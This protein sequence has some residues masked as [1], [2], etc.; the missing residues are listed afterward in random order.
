MALALL[1]FQSAPTSFRMGIAQTMLDEQRHLAA[2]IRKMKTVGIEFG[3]IPV[4]DFFWAQCASMAT[5]FDYVTRMSMTFEQAN[6]DFASYFRD[7][8]RVIG[9][10]D[11]ASLLQ[12][13]LDDEVGHVKHGLT[14]FRRWK[15]ES[16]SDWRAFCEALGG[17]LNP[18]RAKGQ[19]FHEEGRLKAGFCEDY[20]QS[21]KVYSQSKGGLA[22]LSFFNPDAEEELKLA[23]GSYGIKPK[24]ETLR[25]D[26][27]PVMLF[28]L[29]QGDVLVT[30][31][32]L[33]RDFLLQLH[34]VGFELP[35]RLI[36]GKQEIKEFIRTS[37]RQ[38]SHVYPWATAPSV[39]DFASGVQVNVQAATQIDR[40]TLRQV[41]S[42]AFALDAVRD[43]LETHPQ[44][45]SLVEAT[46]LGQVVLD[47]KSFDATIA[48]I[49]SK[50]S[51]SRFIA[52]RPWS[53]SGRHRVIGSLADG[54]FSD[55]PQGIQS[56]LSKSWRMGESPIVQP[57]FNR[58]LDFSVQARIDCHDGKVS[59]HK[60]GLTR[61]VNHPNGQYCASV[62]GRFLSG[63]SE[64]LMRFWHNGTSGHTASIE[65]VMDRMVPF[66]GERLASKGY[67]GPF[68][69]DCFVFEDS[70]GRFKIHPLIE[71]NPRNTM[72]RVA[73]ALSKRMAPGRVGIWLHVPVSWLKQLGC[74]SFDVLRER[75]SQKLP[76]VAHTNSRGTV[77]TSGLIETTPARLCE[78]VWT[79]FIA[80]HHLNETLEELGIAG[81][82]DLNASR[83][84]SDRPG[85]QP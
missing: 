13:V 2:Y 27:E 4:N 63:E 65:A 42:K 76:V 49:V 78:H 55:Q 18:A 54:S 67:S 10:H 47:E 81:L 79:C 30:K 15:T 51:F 17:E 39:L 74:E 22:R 23:V 29:S 34:D 53:A 45:D 52:K 69:V 12:T 59:V 6:L 1:K 33:P 37:G 66:V 25:C 50:S 44:Y 62:V 3:D 83:K 84:S 68:G 9:D 24:L 8:L 57:L 77:L 72:G 64:D 46:D 75:W 38:I 70:S 82:I 21:L 31:R 58:R 85:S 36:G 20:I 73:L 61:I 35:E 26:L 7:V 5:P 16:V 56:W 71:I 40:E 32:E 48:L 11:T 19:F 80:T 60:I 43:F 28:I 41:Y 14:W